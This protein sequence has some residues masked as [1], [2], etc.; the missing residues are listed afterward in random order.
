M[1][2]RATTPAVISKPEQ[3]SVAVAGQLAALDARAEE[4]AQRAS[5]VSTLAE[6][7]HYEGALTVPALEDEIRFYQ[8]RSVEAFLE[9]GKRLLLLKAATPPRGGFE[10]RV[11]ALGIN[12]KMAQRFMSATRK[13]TKSDAKQL[14][15]LPGLNQNKLLELAM[16]DDAELQ[17]L[18]AGEDVRGVTLDKIDCMSTSELRQA[19]RKTSRELEHTVDLKKTAVENRDARINDLEDQLGIRRKDTPEMVEAAVLLKLHEQVMRTVNEIELALRGQLSQVA[20][21]FEDGPLPNHV[22]LAMQ[23]G[24]SQVIQA[25]RIVAGDFGI[26]LEESFQTPVAS[27]AWLTEAEKVFGDGGHSFITEQGDGA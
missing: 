27:L 2:R 15:A 3:D 21:H 13:F 18:E 8:R 26:T 24:F 16:L 10:E 14:L 5:A 23:Q 20:R 9:L 1:G 11:E 19:L 25:A 6:E 4:E 22:T 7:L 12:I 17:V